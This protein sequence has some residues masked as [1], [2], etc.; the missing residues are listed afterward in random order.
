MS[1]QGTQ[2]ISTFFH[3]LFIELSAYRTK[4]DTE[5]YVSNRYHNYN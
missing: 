3:D 1:L 4:A 5:K 2:L